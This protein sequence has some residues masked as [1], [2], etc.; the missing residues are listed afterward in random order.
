MDRARVDGF[1]IDLLPDCQR[2]PRQ[3]R[4]FPGPPPPPLRFSQAAETPGTLR[5]SRSEL[6]ADCEGMLPKLS[7]FLSPAL[8]QCHLAEAHQTVSREA[9]A[10][11]QLFE[12]GQLPPEQALGRVIIASLKSDLAEIVQRRGHGAAFQ[13][14]PFEDFFCTQESGFGSRQVTSGIEHAAIGQEAGDDRIA[15]RCELFP[16]RQRAGRILLG[17]CEVRAACL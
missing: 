3:L 15:L 17:L 2:L 11:I 1:W 14:K 16:D 9:T 7:R 8:L 6:F 10:G 4:R 13:L 5:P 12:E